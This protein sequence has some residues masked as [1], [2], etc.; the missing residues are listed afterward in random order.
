MKVLIILP[1]LHF[2]DSQTF[3][4]CNYRISDFQYFISY[5]F[6]VDL[7]NLSLSIFQ[8]MNQKAFTFKLGC[9]KINQLHLQ[10]FHIHNNVSK[11]ISLMLHCL[12]ILCI[13]H[14]LS[15]QP[16]HRKPWRDIFISWKNSTWKLHLKAVTV[17]F[18]LELHDWSSVQ[19]LNACTHTHSCYFRAPVM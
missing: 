19:K 16:E 18:L 14:F 17:Q 15:K 13:L 12:H 11:L 2:S 3:Q 1:L 6:S 8:Q 10:N 9:L 5:N 7:T 4:E